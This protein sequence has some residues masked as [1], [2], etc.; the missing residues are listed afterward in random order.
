M[1]PPFSLQLVHYS[2]HAFQLDC[3]YDYEW[4]K[5][6]NGPTAKPPGL[7]LSVEGFEGDDEWTWP[8]WCNSQ[9]FCIDKLQYAMDFQITDNARVLLLE[10]SADILQFTDQYKSAWWQR[11]SD[12]GLISQ[13]TAIDWHRM[14]DT[15]DGI[16]IA[17]YDWPSRHE[18]RT[19]WYN[20][21]DCA[22]A[23]IWN[24]DALR[25]GQ[26]AKEAV[27]LHAWSKTYVNVFAVVKS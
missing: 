8:Q 6:E 23:C 2:R 18:S 1:T 21:W 13:N 7:W 11:R 25:V 3:A 24:L 16:V 20:G 17:P 9:E 5:F 10:S 4:H 22:S 27:G 26:Q 14:H 19:R 15:W 12:A